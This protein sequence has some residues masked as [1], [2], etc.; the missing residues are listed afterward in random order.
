MHVVHVIEVKRS[1]PLDAELLEEAERGERIL[2]E[3]EAAAKRL[4]FEVEGDL[5]QAREAGH[6]IIDEAVERGADGIVLG[7][8]F[9]RPFGE[10]EMGHVPAHVLR[11]APCE[12]ILVRMRMDGR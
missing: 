1:L 10:F 12:V 6:A 8:P 4:D 2:D 5:L 11:A 9:R 3:A 7:V